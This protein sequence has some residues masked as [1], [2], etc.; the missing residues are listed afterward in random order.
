MQSKAFHCAGKTF[1]A[2][3]NVLI[4][5]ELG[6]GHGGSLK[7]AKELVSAAADSG[8]DAVKFQIVYADE[9]LH[10]ATGVVQLPGGAVSLYEQ[11]KKLE[12]SKSFFVELAEYC[13]ERNILFSASPFGL[14]SLDELAQLNTS[15][16]KIA[17]PELNYVQ[18]LEAVSTKKIPL[19]LS[20]GVS[21]LA[22]IERA[23]A[24]VRAEKDIALLHCIT[25]YPAPESEYNVS[26]VQS[27]QT[28]FNLP[29]GI[30]DHSLDPIAVPV[31]SV[32]CGACIIEKHFCLSHDDGGLDDKIALTPSDFSRMASA[33]RGCSGKDT[34]D[35]MEYLQHEGFIKEYLISILGTGKKTLAESEK[36]NYGRTN[37]S[38]HYMGSLKAGTKI[39][40]QDIAILR[41]EK[42]LSAGE[43]PELLNL[44]IG[45]VLQKDVQ[46]GSGAKLT[47]IIS[48]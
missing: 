24:A 16:I 12:V 9:I 7:K 43:S 42:I 22:D 41:T 23:V 13:G 2:P 8:A 28:I 10:P 18:L 25:S 48:R 32:A 14:R 21:R 30:S 11:F 17:S 19:V 27:L 36:K 44:F 33:V 6:T 39:S 29:V 37:R 34:A 3:S 26:L 4:V 35:I 15:F 40:A 1:S 38:L 47:D 20:T 5:A 46:S 31:L 45:S